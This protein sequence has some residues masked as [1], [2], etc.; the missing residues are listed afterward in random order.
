MLSKESMHNSLPGCDVDVGIAMA[1]K[2]DRV[3]LRMQINMY[4]VDT[5]I[6]KQ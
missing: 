5:S 1:L 6:V 3:Q 2:T 4:N